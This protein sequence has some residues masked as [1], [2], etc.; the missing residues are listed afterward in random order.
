MNAAVV[1]LN[2]RKLVLHVNNIVLIKSY[3]NGCEVIFEDNSVKYY[4]ITP[5]AYISKLCL[6]A[7]SSFEGRTSSFKLL[8]NTT[9]KPC[10]YV[11]ESC[12]FIPSAS[13]SLKDTEYVNYHCISLY[14]KD[15]Y[16][17]KIVSLSGYE[18]IIHASYH[19]IHVQYT[20][21]TLFLNELYKN[22]TLMIKGEL[23]DNI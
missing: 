15:D 14:K 2:V 19:T 9:Q 17:T 12:L 16:N 3:Q 5:K 22:K 23:Y 10:I 8:T 7:G 11:N 6:L 13:S 4:T 21:S 1:M 18:Y 20:R